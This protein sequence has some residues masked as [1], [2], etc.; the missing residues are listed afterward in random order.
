MR[1]LT[2]RFTPGNRVGLLRSG[3][4]YFP[5]L[6]SAIESAE[7]EVWLETYIFADDPAGRL[8]ADALV[9]AAGVP[10]PGGVRPSFSLCVV[11]IAPLPVR[12]AN[13]YGR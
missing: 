10:T 7:R 1:A 5:A 8:V 4:E 13:G 2:A 3:R 11:G 12:C 6:V 9:R